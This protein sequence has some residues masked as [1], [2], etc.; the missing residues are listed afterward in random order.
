MAQI[1]I[2]RINEW[3]NKRF[4]Y[5]LRQNGQVIAELHPGDEKQLA[6]QE[7][8]VLQA[9][10]MWCGSESLKLSA[11]DERKEI[12][13]KADKGIH[14]LVLIAPLLIICSISL[15][16]L[17]IGNIPFFGGFINGLLAG[18]MLALLY[19]VSFGRNKWLKLIVK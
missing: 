10:I 3:F 9:K 14:R 17:D 12:E 13:V 2:K 16:Q 15:H 7:E 5:E 4:T 6:I 18:I 19:L 8:T 1:T 11:T